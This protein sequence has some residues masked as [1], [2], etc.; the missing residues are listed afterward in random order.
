MDGC[1]GLDEAV[2]RRARLGLF[3]GL[4][5]V[6]LVL[7]ASSAVLAQ[8]VKLIFDT[9]MGNDVDDVIALAM[10]HNLQRRGAVELL[11][12]TITKDH[13][14]AA[15][16][17][18]AVNTFYGQGHVPIG[19]VRDGAAKDLGRF[20]ALADSR[21]QDGSPRYPHRL[22]SGAD[23]P[24]AV[25]LIRSLLAAQPDGSVTIA[26]VGFFT[27]CA[28]LLDS[29]GDE[30]SPLS[31][32]ELVARKVKVLTL[33]AGAFQTVNWNTRHL[34]YNVRVDV[35]A[36]Q[37]VAREWPTPVVWSGFEVG[38]AAAF[39]HVSIERDLNYVAHHPLKDA[40]YLYQPP[41]H[42]RPTWDPTTVLH[43]VLP[44]RGYF[45]LSPPGTVTVG[46][47]GATHFRPGA[48]GAGRHRFLVMNREQAA[49]VREAIVQ[50]SVEPPAAR[51]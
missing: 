17:T 49:R 51:P 18:D 47:D 36:A 26:Q 4:L 45:D 37:K 10:I 39:P 33:M 38:M 43:A 23:A 48:D 16:F 28:R 21:K 31:G 34:E 50:L 29:P 11:A 40:Y 1:H 7:A 46:D 25:A 14:Q 12:V 13:P 2:M 44:D 24:E 42:D 22:K 32:R 30:H 9:D 41:P 19:V 20:I 27:N 6:W 8:P 35:P 15:A 3:R 5:V